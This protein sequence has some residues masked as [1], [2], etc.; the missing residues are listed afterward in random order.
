MVQFST[1]LTQLRLLPIKPKSMINRINTTKR[2]LNVVTNSNEAAAQNYPKVVVGRN[3]WARMDNTGL[4]T[5]GLLKGCSTMLL[6]N[7]QISTKTRRG[8]S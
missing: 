8:A 1:G 6:L 2:S 4:G 5:V 3:N 7:N